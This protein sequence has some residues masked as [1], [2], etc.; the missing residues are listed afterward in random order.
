MRLGGTDASEK[1]A[2]HEIAWNSDIVK[3][4]LR[5]WRELL[6]A[7]Y[8][9]DAPQMLATDWDNAADAVL[10][11]AKGGYFQLG[12]WINNRAQATYKLSPGKDY[13]LFQFPSLGVGFD[14][15][16]SVDSKEFLA[17]NSGRNSEAADAFLDFAIS[18][19]G[20]AI[21]AKHGFTSPSKALDSSLLDP[22]SKISY[23]LVAGKDVIFV[24]GDRLPSELGDEYRIQFQ[25]F[26]QDS[27]D[28]NIDKITNALEAKAKEVY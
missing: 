7:G 24:L 3:K 22:V 18:A 1:L 28:A 20:A 13:S 23:D 12:M 26:L 5:T 15:T 11:D 8:G 4:T 17:I 21:F 9:G 14:N 16:S 25:K 6:Q 10:K 27:S 2:N 19:E